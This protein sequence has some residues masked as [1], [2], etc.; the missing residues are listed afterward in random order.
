MNQ[1]NRPEHD[2]HAYGERITLWDRYSQH[3][4]IEFDGD[5]SGSII[6]QA[7]QSP[8]TWPTPGLDS[9]ATE[10]DHRWVG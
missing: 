10:W 3:W 2:C 1:C 5:G 8:D 7:M 9:W 6:D 4:T